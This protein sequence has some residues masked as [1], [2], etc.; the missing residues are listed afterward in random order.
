MTAPVERLVATLI[1]HGLTLATA[2]SVTG[3]MCAWALIEVPDSGQVMLG[4]VVAYSSVEKHRVLGV[5]EGP[6]ISASCARQMAG[7]V[8]KLFGADCALAFTGVA[9]PTEQDGQP[10]GTVFIAA[11]TGTAE[12]TRHF[13][14]DGNPTEIRMLAIE[15]GARLL[16]DL[17]AEEAGR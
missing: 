5:D 2:E 17:V 14:F 13:R 11:V 4:S 8:I 9:G 10:V 3:G 15:A 6:V 16:T 7:G 12:R 1:E